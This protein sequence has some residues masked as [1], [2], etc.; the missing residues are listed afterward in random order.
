VADPWTA[1][2]FLVPGTWYDW[3]KRV[4]DRELVSRMLSWEES[5]FH[6]LVRMIT[7]EKNLS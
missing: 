4:Q 6:E 3:Q 2:G 7:T 5:R 1:G